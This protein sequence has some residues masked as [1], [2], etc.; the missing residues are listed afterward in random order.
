[1]PHANPLD[2]KSYRTRIFFMFFTYAKKENA[3]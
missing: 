1:M 3:A 2:K